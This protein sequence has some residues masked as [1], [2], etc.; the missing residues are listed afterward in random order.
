MYAGTRVKITGKM[1]ALST[2]GASH[3]ALIK[4]GLD[5]IFAAPLLWRPDPR[6]VW[7]EDHS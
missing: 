3:V 1:L 4:L 2:N 6:H 5:S 7:L